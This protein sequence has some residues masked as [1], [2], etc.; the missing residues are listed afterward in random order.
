MQFLPP[1]IFV[2]FGSNLLT[3]GR[4]LSQE[5]CGPLTEAE[6]H[7]GSVCDTFWLRDKQENVAAM[8]VMN[9]MVLIVMTYF[10]RLNYRYVKLN[11]EL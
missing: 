2:V 1:F 8:L 10:N 3:L 11:V 7:M 4:S 9:K 5:V 6:L